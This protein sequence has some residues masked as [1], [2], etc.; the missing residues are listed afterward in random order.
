MR[1]VGDDLLAVRS[2]GHGELNRLRE[3]ANQA[4]GPLA[5]SISIE[6]TQLLRRQIARRCIYGVDLNPIAVDLARLAIW[7]RDNRGDRKLLACL[8]DC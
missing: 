3:C 6:D 4:L 1:R 7:I 5:A 8:H 2:N